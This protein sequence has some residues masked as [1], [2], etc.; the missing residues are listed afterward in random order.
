MN[1]NDHLLKPEQ[2]A[3]RLNVSVDWVRDHSSRKMPRLP[4][5][6]LGGGP[7]RAGL[8]RYRASEIEK[9]IE[10]MERQSGKRRVQ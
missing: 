10:E 8:L 7:G 5:I 3:E 1:A 2:V 4:V 9:F 6:R